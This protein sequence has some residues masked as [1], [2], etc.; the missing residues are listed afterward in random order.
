M[1]TRYEDNSD[2]T[3]VIINDYKLRKGVAKDI[4]YGKIQW[5]TAGHEASLL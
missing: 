3:G 4:R 2:G 5:F 1:V